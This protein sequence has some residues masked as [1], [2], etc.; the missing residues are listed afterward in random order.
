MIQ[1]K[2]LVGTHRLFYRVILTVSGAEKRMPVQKLAIV[3]K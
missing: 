2:P 1:A 3:S